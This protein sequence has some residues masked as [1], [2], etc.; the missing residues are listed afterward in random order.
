M[1]TGKMAERS[2]NW[3]ALVT[4]AA[5]FGPAATFMLESDISKVPEELV[6]EYTLLA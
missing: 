6:A 1:R 4:A 5:S 2:I 3:P